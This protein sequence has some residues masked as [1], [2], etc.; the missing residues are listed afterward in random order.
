MSKTLK[1]FLH[2]LWQSILFWTITMLLWGVF[3]FFGLEDSPGI[4][5]NA[6]SQ[7]NLDMTEI[8]SLFA[9]AGFL[10]GILYATIEF[11]FE[12]YGSKRRAIGLTVVMKTIIY[13]FIIILLSTSMIELGGELFGVEKSNELGWWRSDKSFWVTVLYFMLS[14]LI[15]SFIKIANEKFGPG[16]FLKML[17]GTYKNPKEEKRIFMFLDLKS[18]TSIAETLGHLKYSQLIQDCFYDLNEVVPQYAAEIYQYVGDEAVLSWS[19]SKGL[20]N[21]NCV[22]LFFAFQTLLNTR[23]AYYTKKYGLLPEF[24]AGLHGGDLMVAEVGVVKKELAFHGDVINTSARIQAA[25]NTHDV[26]VLMSE[27][28]K[29]DLKV[30]HRYSTQFIG[31]LP[32]KGKKEAS[33]VYT[34]FEA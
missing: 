19:Y 16:I 29:E 12:K 14:S 24:K 5:I 34:I 3:R 17:W 26:A 15:F 1:T 21:N 28:L 11:V 7:H 23:S 8:L 31:N 33:N 32:L 20:A 6:E 18:S 22:A 30:G 10:F 4:L 9:L 25:C 13:L 2:Y 27:K